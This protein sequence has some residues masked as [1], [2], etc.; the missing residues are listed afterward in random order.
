M[1][2]FRVENYSIEVFVAN[3]PRRE[4]NT[5]C[6]KEPILNNFVTW[7]GKICTVMIASIKYHENI[8]SFTKCN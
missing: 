4:I 1:S 8:N 6:V 5:P 3:C 7:Y 2:R